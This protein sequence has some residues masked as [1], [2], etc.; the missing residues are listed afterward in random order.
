MMEIP[1]GS[2]ILV[3]AAAR[4]IHHDVIAKLVSMVS[5]V[6]EVEAAFIPQILVQG[7]ISE[8]RQVLVVVCSAA[9]KLVVAKM[10]ENV[11]RI[12]GHGE[13]LDILPV[14]PDDQLLPLVVRSKTEIFRREPHR[15]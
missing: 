4:P 15:D 6:A 5:Q 9:N 12:I 1:P 10:A 3:G 7:L 14:R 13:H 2:H 8:P 11:R